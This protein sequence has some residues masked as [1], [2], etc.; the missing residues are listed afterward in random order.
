M[1]RCYVPERYNP[2]QTFVA[3]DYWKPADLDIA[4]VL[5]DLID[6]LVVEAILHVRAHDA[7]DRRHGGQALGDGANRNVAVGD[8]TYEL[9]L[10]A[11]RKCARVQLRHF[12]RRVL[13]R[14]VRTRDFYAAGHDVANFHRNLHVL[15]SLWLENA[16]AEPMFRIRCYPTPP[17]GESFDH[18]VG[19]GNQGCGQLEA[20][21]V[22]GL[23]VD[24]QLEL[25]RLLD[26][27]ICGLRA[28][29]DLV[30]VSGAAPKEVGKIGPVRDEATGRG[31]VP[32]TVDRRQT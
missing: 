25:G 1:G 16:R 11:D 22:R 27:Q 17:H 29:E 5:H 7:S 4:H 19:A 32:E 21:R 14:V 2:D 8:H 26:W 12:P 30:H 3:I 24:D 15:W 13:N 10:F 6:V 28:L 31:N 18:F 9:V 20:E 23:E